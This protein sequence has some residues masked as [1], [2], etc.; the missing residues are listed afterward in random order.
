MTKLLSKLLLIFIIKSSFGQTVLPSIIS[1]NTVLFKQN[2][3]YVINSST[4]VSDNITL[5]IEAGV[6]ITILEH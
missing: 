4:L 6:D 5:T 3:P 1:Q 2:S